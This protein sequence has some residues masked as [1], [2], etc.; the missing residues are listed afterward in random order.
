MKEKIIIIALAFVGGIFPILLN[1]FKRKSASNPIPENVRDVYDEETYGKWRSYKRD[2]SRLDLISCIV[3]LLLTLSML[4][5]NVYS[6]FA[7][8]FPSGLHWQVISVILLETVISMVVGVIFSY[9]S[10]M[11]IEENYGFNKSTVKTFIVDKIREL[12]LS[13]LLGLFLAFTMAGLHIW[14][15]DYVIILFTVVMF[16]FS[17]LVSFLYPFFSRIGNKF[18]PLE[19]GELREKLM[20]LLTSHGYKVRDI[21]VMDASRRTTKLNA[22]FTGFGS[23][24]TIVLYD[25]LVNAMSTEEICAVFAHEL[26]HGLHKDVLKMQIMNIG[27]M[28]LMAVAVWLSVREG[29]LH[30]AFGFTEVNYGFAYILTGIFISLIQPLTGMLI[31]AY[32]RRAEYRADEQAV[33]E[34]YGQAMT[35]ALKKL[36]R[37]NFSE[38]APT[39]ISVLLEYSHPPL[40]D[41]IAAVEKLLDAK[42]NKR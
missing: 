24:K 3:S 39:K 37:E 12:I 26:G 15:G 33:S 21:Q 18:T 30:T 20:E 29:G 1:L 7:S 32:S 11:V 19:E 13:V 10:T 42:E 22:Y 38:L 28:L 2:H 40:S 17:L 35:G 6:A 27:N 4:A 8:L 34:G 14:L 23:T 36:A 5:T 9:Y 25:N 31:N 16:L 41:R